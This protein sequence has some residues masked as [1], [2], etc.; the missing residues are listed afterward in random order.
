[1]RSRRIDTETLVAQTRGRV[2]TVQDLSSTV[3]G[4]VFVMVDCGLD[5]P[6]DAAL[7]AASMSREDAIESVELSHRRTFGG[8]EL[9][10]WTWTIS[11]WRDG[12]RSS[13]T[14]GCVE[15]LA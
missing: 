3:T 8:V 10:G 13:I 9:I 5:T 2:L 15:D 4:R 14:S 7:A 11:A 12:A 6:A 1:M